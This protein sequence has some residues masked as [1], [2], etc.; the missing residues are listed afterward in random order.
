[1]RVLVTGGA[2][3]QGSHLVER[4]L[5]DDHEITILNTFSES[6]ERNIDPFAR[7]IA[8]VWGS[9]TD[10]EI[11]EKTVRGQDAVIHL[12]ARISVD[13]SIHDPSSYLSVNVMGTYNVLEALRRSRA[14]L[15]YSSSCEVY[16]DSAGA[17]A[18]ERSELRPHSPYA[19]SKA[20]ADRLCF[21]YRKTY[22][23][24]TTI[25]RPSNIY[26]PRQR[27]GKGGAVIPIFVERA[28]AGN[29]LVVFG[30]GLQ[31]R[32]YMHVDDVVAGYA[33]VLER[34]DV[35]GEVINLGTGETPSI[36]EIAAFIATELG[37][38]VED[39]PPRPGEVSG[40]TL[41]TAKA[42]K[43]GFAPRVPF[44]EGL[45]RYI[46]WARTSATPPA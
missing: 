7:R 37:V 25:V 18:D 39:G 11:V 45:T 40:F 32:E 13:E 36:K 42:T 10:R 41:D 17:A 38:E 44:W 29:A 46:E 19:A 23:V 9:V 43:L 8:A 33:L 3:F 6:A 14:R 16:G 2:G 30:T 24:Q 15:I 27:G 20:A 1:M 12:A 28:L 4:L 34:D 5:G 22:D 21:A 35:G 31:R 26:G